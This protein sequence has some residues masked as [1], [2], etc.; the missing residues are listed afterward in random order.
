[1]NIVLEISYIGT[2]YFGWQIQPNKI[3]VQGEL[4]KA[5]ESVFNQKITTIASGRTDAGVSAFKQVVNFR[6]DTIIPVDRLKYILNDKLPKDIRVIDSYVVADDFNAR[7][8]A[9][10]KTY[11]YN[12]YFGDVENALIS[13][14]SLFLK[15]TLDIERMSDACKYFLGEHDFTGFCS[16]DT[17]VVDKVRTIYDIKILKSDYDYKLIIT[18]NGFLYNMVRII[19]GT[20]ID[21]GYGKIKPNEI[22]DIIESKDRKRAGYTVKPVGLILYNVQY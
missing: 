22:T 7:F 9:K 11:V 20:L 12:F 3:T 13:E 4:E 5:L 8:S 16:A 15:G 10:R 17:E 18:G 2:R 6:V 21:V 14:H 1:M 19:M